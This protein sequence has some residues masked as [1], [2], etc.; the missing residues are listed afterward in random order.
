M[1]KRLKKVLSALSALAVLV[2][3][4][5][6]ITMIPATAEDTY[7]TKTVVDDIYNSGY[8]IAF[9]KTNYTGAGS[10]SNINIATPNNAWLIETGKSYLFPY[11]SGIKEPDCAVIWKMDTGF[12]SFFV[13]TF[14]FKANANEEFI[15]SY[16]AFFYSAD[17]ENW[18]P[19]DYTV[20]EKTDISTGS[21][22]CRVTVENIPDDARYMK[23]LSRVTEET[24]DYAW[25]T[26]F[27]R[28]G[29]TYKELL[30]P[31]EIDAEYKNYYGV[32][33]NPMTDGAK[34]IREAK[35]TVSNIGESTGGNLTVTKDGREINAGNL[36]SD[37][38]KA[39][40]FTED[41]EYAVQAENYAGASSFSFTLKKEEESEEVIIKT[42]IDD[43][44]NTGKTTAIEK[45]N[46]TG[47]GSSSNINI[48]T[49][50]NAW[51]IETGKSYLFPYVSGITE[52]DCA[53][54]WKMDTSFG[55]FFVDT[56]QFKANANEN[57]IR[58]YY[59]FFY[60]ADGKNWTQADYTVGE[61]RDI[62][63][64]SA[65]CRVTV[66]KI[67]D[68]A[69]YMKY[70]SLTTEE[71]KDD[72]WQTGFIRA[73]YTTYVLLPEINAAFED[74]VGVFSAPIC[75]GAVVPSK[76]KVEYSDV[77]EDI[78][79]NTVVKK[80]GAV[81]TL[82][83]DGILTENGEYEIIAENIKGRTSLCF[84]IDQSKAQVKSEAYVFSEGAERAQG[85]YDK[86]LGITPDGAS[87][88]FTKGDGH[89]IVNDTGILKHSDNLPW[90]G[91]T[92]G[93]TKLTVG[94]DAKGYTKDGYFYFVNVGS[95]GAKY[96]GFSITYTKARQ[97]VFPRDAYFTVYTADQYNGTYRQVEPIYITMD[98]HKGGDPAAAV[99]HAT[100]YLGSEASVV[101]I[102]FH[103]QSP[104]GSEWMGSFLSILNLTKL[105]MPVVEAKSGNTLL[106]DNQITQNDVK[107]NVSNE[108]YY[109]VE[110]DGAKVEL[111][112][113]KILSED[114]FYT[115][116]ACN[117]AGAST[118]SFYIAKKNP[119]IQLIDSTGNFMSD[120]ASVSDDVKVIFYNADSAE[121]LRDGALYSN[122]RE[123]TLDLNGTYKLKAENQF[124]IFERSFTLN[125]PLPTVKAYNFQ[126]KQI[127]D[128]ETIVTTATYS[129]ET[130]DSYTI[131]LNGKP[132]EPTDKLTQE[133]DYVIEAVNKAGT[134]A[135]AFTIKYNPPLPAV[136]HAGD[137]VAKFNY[138]LKST[139]KSYVKWQ[140]T[141]FKF[142]NVVF[143]NSSALKSGW[144]GFTGG[145]IHTVET[146][147]DGTLIYKAPGFK[148]FHLYTVSYPCKTVPFEQMFTIYG[149]VNGRD[150]TE[151]A[152]TVEH[153]ISYITTG[154]QKYR[155][156][157]DSIPEGCKYIK[158]IINQQDNDATWYRCITDVEY[159]YDKANVGK[160][161]VDDILNMLEDS[162]EGD[163]VTADVY[164]GD[165]VIP[166]R[167]FAALQDNDKNLRINLMD[168]NGDTEYY[169]IFN[170]LQI[171]EPMD[172]NIGVSEGSTSGSKLLKAFDSEAS[173]I[174]FNQKGEW[175]LGLTLGIGIKNR[176]KG[177]KY[178]LYMYK[179]GEFS[180]VETKLFT[181][182]G[183]F[184][185]ELPESAD[186]ILCRKADLVKEEE[187]PDISDTVIDTD[188]DEDA[189]TYTMVR[190][191]KKFVPNNQEKQGYT[192]LI[193]VIC[194]AAAVIIT[195]A[196][197]L[198]IL[199]KKGKIKL[200]KGR[201]S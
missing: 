188:P 121:I 61:K 113:D 46:Y 108:L 66:D 55:S 101:K 49:P 191:L 102:E 182:N 1:N 92:E 72:G 129:I 184:S 45:T 64:G 2:S 111:P 163:T 15:T 105:S 54:I 148:S 44:Y 82:P 60:S 9:K 76:V 57:F 166:K 162:Y 10:S 50:N 194:V 59:A 152:C 35:M 27:I 62:S 192:W 5:A 96:N 151:L 103:P 53:V 199:V 19:A 124:G 158:V 34:I 29:Y 87:A 20:G 133:G 186:Y 33:A 201:K 81:I 97:A 11:V 17:G 132:I 40:I 195:A 138:Q 180:L 90:W 160:L 38:E 168:E 99:Y 77:G 144:T 41:G 56:F 28:A 172:F 93:G 68:D 159:S 83:A 6:C 120:N 114:G 18:T 31:P 22:S 187:D 80:D 125:R 52:P 156:V 51:L 14:Q 131:K 69:R 94:S 25:Q 74:S 30:L 134:T 127:T 137:T 106:V 119:A 200:P 169:L 130:A 117:Y 32:Y 147:M 85:D 146:S 116:T 37:D 95:D 171:T 145:V 173:G 196:T 181:A 86:L 153:D 16:Y 115:V 128:G 176:A 157:A 112:A 149:S 179:N 39:Y 140:D 104:L 123:V 43:I 13:D 139:D 143:D 21:A 167:V 135:L 185:V 75:D 142:D 174:I 136:G 170:G 73:G 47:A 48:A 164:N 4:V 118:V 155:F 122:E 91:L 84:T 109:Y 177:E 78:N 36:Y 26:G 42:V 198:I 98:S 161:D 23:Y 71:T 65:S 165:A 183:F 150:F 88:D 12:T 110:K 178:T 67:P 58:R 189:G 8:T 193:V 141:L 100:Y 175:T 70:L 24:K 79:G 3:A 154:Y 63:S 107:I 197:V 126:N 89:I 190:T 7:I